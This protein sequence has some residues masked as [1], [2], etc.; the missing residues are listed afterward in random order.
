MER[1]MVGNGG[2]EE[3]A[4]LLLATRRTAVVADENETIGGRERRRVG[5]PL[6]ELPPRGDD[7]LGH[8]RPSTAL[9]ATIGMVDRVL[10]FIC[11]CIAG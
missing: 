4:G 3:A 2:R 1:A 8:R 11:R 7:L 10:S 6:G 5:K 9:A